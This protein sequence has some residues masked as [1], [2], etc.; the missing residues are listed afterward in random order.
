[1]Q[2]DV[3]GVDVKSIRKRLKLNQTDFGKL[4]GVSL[5]SVQAYEKGDTKP[6]ADVLL[7]ILELNTKNDAHNNYD[8]PISNYPVNEPLSFIKNKN[9]L[10]FE[11]LPNGKFLVEV[12]KIPYNAYAS[13]IEVFG[14]EYAIKEMFE[15]TVFTVDHPGKGNY[16]SFTVRNDSMNGGGIF[17]TPS[18][19]D[20]L[21]RLIQK[22][23]WKDGF[24]P[25][26]KGF[27]VI[28]Y[29]GIFH[30]DIE[31]PDLEGN[32]TCKSRN[33]SPEFPDFKLN[34]NEVHTIW[35]V[36]KRTF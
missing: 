17:D 1:M 21:G 26:E 4:I 9:G 36:L 28:S 3:Q 32:I 12:P 18:G 6:S 10:T 5:R 14:D 34:L 27:I 35:R 8:Q 19:A 33:K 30:K 16:L 7:K 31:G 2:N 25:S 29:N 11:E 20:V 22:H 24:R 23:H 13:F 15:T